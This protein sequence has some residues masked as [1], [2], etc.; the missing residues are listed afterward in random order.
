[1]KQKII[2]KDK[3]HLQELI[4]NEIE[5]HGNECDLNHIDVS[6]VTDTSCIF[7]NSQFNGDISKWDVSSVV[8]MGCSFSGSKFNGDISQWDVSNINDM[9]YMFNNSKFNRNLSK[10]K[11]Y[12]LKGKENIFKDSPLE[13]HQPYWA[14]VDCDLIKSS[15]DNYELNKKLNKELFSN[16]IKKNKIKI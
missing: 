1:M 13:N 8:N 11:P 16:L 3:P 5:L 9:A 2:A 4:Q 14:T 12:N 10:W 6:S 7:F 15:I